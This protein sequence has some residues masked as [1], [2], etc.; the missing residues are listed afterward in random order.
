MTSDH[1]DYVERQAER[2]FGFHSQTYDGLRNETR[3]LLSLLIV[4]T[5]ASFG[6]A[7]DLAARELVE[8]KW[9]VGGRCDD[10]VPG[11]PRHHPRSDWESLRFCTPRLQTSPR[12]LR[13]KGS[14]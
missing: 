13:S 3:S 12:T 6:L 2:N 11:D 10:A 14:S 8:I 4:L 7:A 9:A 1:L 5:G